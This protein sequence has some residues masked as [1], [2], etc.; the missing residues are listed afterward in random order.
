[1]AALGSGVDALSIAAPVLK[2]G[3]SA[4]ETTIARMG[5]EGD[6]AKLAA[7]KDAEKAKAKAERGK[8]FEMDLGTV[9]LPDTIA[10][11][12]RMADEQA[13][14]AEELQAFEEGKGEDPDDPRSLAGQKRM[15]RLQGYK[16][17]VSNSKQKVAHGNTLLALIRANP[18]AYEE[19]AEEAVLAWMSD[20]NVNDTG[21]LIDPAE[22]Y[23]DLDADLNKIMDDVAI[24]G[25][26]NAGRDANGDVLTTGAEYIR[27]ED[28]LS[29]V[30]LVLQKPV[31]FNE[32][33]RRLAKIEARD[34]SLAAEILAISD[35]KK[36]SKEAALL[37]KEAEPVYGYSKSTQSLSQQS[38]GGAGRKDYDSGVNWLAE[39]TKSVVEGSFKGEQGAFP[40]IGIGALGGATPLK[41]QE[42]AGG[43]KTPEENL[44]VFK[45]WTMKKQ[46]TYINAGGAGGKKLAPNDIVVEQVAYDRDKGEWVLSTVASATGTKNTFRF[47]N[48]EWE[49]DV[50]PTLIAENKD[51]IQGIGGYVNTEQVS[52]NFEGKDAQNMAGAEKGVRKPAYQSET[53]TRGKAY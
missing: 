47:A 33:T 44:K 41:G 16:Q 20:P 7:A 1:M 10:W 46:Q 51:K 30:Q 35:K 48:S 39:L 4:Y 22:Q 13:T 34:P 17:W 2:S 26:Q 24:S 29:G 53:K 9:E 8:A 3:P 6:N 43:G 38:E 40:A 42:I 37:Y 11:N 21:D 23:Y 18:H 15:A 31:A 25:Y 27:P 52:Q 28:I 50:Y 45:G 19:G 14:Y 32:A 49:S 36:I 5:I 12:K